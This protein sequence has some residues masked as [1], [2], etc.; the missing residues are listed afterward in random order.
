MATA[1][2]GTWDGLRSV[3]AVLVSDD[4]GRDVLWP[5]QLPASHVSHGMGRLNL[6][7]T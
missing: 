5:C 6:Y 4:Q 1:L 3:Q 7:P 2:G